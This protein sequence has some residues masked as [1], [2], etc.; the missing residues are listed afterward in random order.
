MALLL[1]GEL[2][3]VVLP[4]AITDRSGGTGL[5]SYMMGLPQRRQNVPDPES[6]VKFSARSCSIRLIRSDSFEAFGRLFQH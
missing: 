5:I 1:L 2:L 6:C 3:A 4:S